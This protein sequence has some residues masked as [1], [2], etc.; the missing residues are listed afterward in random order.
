[1]PSL[2]TQTPGWYL[3]KHVHTYLDKQQSYLL[4][5]G[6][7]LHHTSLDL[8]QFSG[9]PSPLHLCR[10]KTDNS[11]IRHLSFLLTQ[12]TS[13]Q[14]DWL[15]KWQVSFAKCTFHSF[16]CISTLWVKSKNNNWI[17][18]SSSK[19]RQMPLWT[20]TIMRIIITLTIIYSA[21]SLKNY[22]L[23]VLYCV[24]YYQ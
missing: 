18:A 14:K 2:V 15:Q 8:E 7:N 22:Q 4:W 6:N 23:H 1:M 20:A 9:I 5:F 3:S 19:W 16:S 12:K 17:R 13:R 24:H 10:V 21:I 11:S